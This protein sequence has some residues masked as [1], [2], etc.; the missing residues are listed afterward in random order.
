MLKN[1]HKAKN[2]I[3]GILAAIFMA[4]FFL[5]HPVKIQAQQEMFYLIAGSFD[6]FETAS[7]M[8]TS[9]KTKGFNPLV[10]FPDVTSKKY[11]V[12]VY[13]S[14]NRKE[15]ES[16]STALKAKDK[17]TKSFWI[18][19]QQDPTFAQAQTTRSTDSGDSNKRVKKDEKKKKVKL[20][21]T[22]PVYHLIR[23]SVNSFETAQEQANALTAKGYE[24]YI[25][26]PT[27]N[28]TG[29]RV[30]VYASNDREEVQA[31]SDLL[32][33][34]GESSGWIL[35]EK[36][37]TSQKSTLGVP[38]AAQARIS[39]GEGLTYHLIGGSYKGFDQASEYADKMKAKGYDPLIMFP[40][41]GKYDSFRVSVFR[42]TDKNAVTLFNQSMIKKGEKGGW[43][44]E[45]K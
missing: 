17:N 36:P 6:S 23:G 25:L 19:S 38:M 11:R 5:F 44:Y 14:L 28:Q 22:K 9:L 39:A 33:K 3:T 13:H 40:E 1:K 18:F 41:L 42:S 31:Y 34:K 32:K 26:F 35:E 21:Q 8:V 24:P 27:G 29:Y 30:S 45:Q 7:E 2:G 43:V 4:G 15:V 12:S 16:F 10:I 37:G 20:D